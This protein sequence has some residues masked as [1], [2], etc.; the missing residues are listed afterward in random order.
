MLFLVSLKTRKEKAIREH[1]LSASCNVKTSAYLP[2]LLLSLPPSTKEARKSVGTWKG[3]GN[4][5]LPHHL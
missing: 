2:F 1:I 3:R 4:P 5:T